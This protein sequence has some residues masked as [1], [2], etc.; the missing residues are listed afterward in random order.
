M[1]SWFSLGKRLM[2]ATEVAPGTKDGVVA[3]KDNSKDSKQR[4]AFEELEMKEKKEKKRKKEEVISI[5]RRGR[6]RE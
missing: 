1:D 3:L 6:K 4:S 2:E 5:Q